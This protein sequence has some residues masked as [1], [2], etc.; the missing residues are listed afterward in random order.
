MYL[1]LFAASHFC[2][3]ILFISDK[4]VFKESP[5]AIQKSCDHFLFLALLQFHFAFDMF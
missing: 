2:F 1:D 3:N 5:R 4:L